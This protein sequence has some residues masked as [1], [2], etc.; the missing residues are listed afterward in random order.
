L[1]RQKLVID[2]QYRRF[3]S[4]RVTL[5]KNG[6]GTRD[7][8]KLP[9]EPVAP[10]LKAPVALD[11]IRVLGAVLS[12]VTGMLVQPALV[13]IALI[14][15]IVRIAAQ[16][17]SPPPAPA[18]ILA[19]VTIAVVLIRVLKT[20]PK[21]TATTLAANDHWNLPGKKTIRM[22]QCRGLSK[23]RPASGSSRKPY[24]RWA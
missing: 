5:C 11:V 13:A 18:L 16:L 19:G 10:F 9:P 14:G 1:C 21:T 24:D 3:F 6:P 8:G 22:F 23:N 17:G 15:A 20:P 7:G 12:I 2:C 4:A